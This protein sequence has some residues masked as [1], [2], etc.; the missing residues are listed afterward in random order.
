MVYARVL[1]LQA[2][3]DVEYYLY[4]LLYN[5]IYVIPLATIVLV[6]TATMGRRKLT[7]REG[8]ILKLVSGFMMLGLGVVLLVAPEALNSLM[9]G[10][11]LMG[12]AFLLALIISRIEKFRAG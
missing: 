6:F 8:R 12:M 4:L 3:G 11:G 2:G 7:E 5:I 10:I 9:T 1:T